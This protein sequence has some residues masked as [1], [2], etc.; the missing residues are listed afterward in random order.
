MTAKRTASIYPSAEEIN[1][2]PEKVRQYIHDLVT[3]CDK[4]GDVQTI[5]ILREDRDALQIHVEELETERLK[6]K[7]KRN[8]HCPVPNCRGRAPHEDD[9]AVV[10]LMEM[11]KYR[12]AILAGYAFT[13]LN[14]LKNSIIRDIENDDII[15][16]ITRSRQVEELYVS[17][18]YALLVANE[19]EIPH[20]FSEVFP[21]GLGLAY[22]QVNELAFAGKGQLHMT[23]EDPD[24]REMRILDLFNQ[25]AH[26][27][28]LSLLLAGKFYQFP[29]RTSTAA[30]FVERVK[31]YC[32]HL[33][34]ITQDFAAG[35]SRD[36]ILRTLRSQYGQQA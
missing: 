10:H 26:V 3:R 22:K 20:F 18:I 14:A 8:P 13:G 29:E 25:T 30:A 11:V 27:S 4:S 19:D 24:L 32:D 31:T 1:T 16:W 36:E 7:R 35:K 28:F 5:A 33:L 34:H 6:R 21:N 12:P 2:L 15:A 17:S 23:S 9:P